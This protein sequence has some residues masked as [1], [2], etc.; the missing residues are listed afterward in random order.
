M[1]SAER[2]FGQMVLRENQRA[3]VDLTY[4]PHGRY[5]GNVLEQRAR[6]TVTCCDAGADGELEARA[7]A[8]AAGARGA[9]RPPLEGQI[10]RVS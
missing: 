5:G 1:L 3:R 10:L 2:G 8:T 9:V 6:H 4:Q 7:R